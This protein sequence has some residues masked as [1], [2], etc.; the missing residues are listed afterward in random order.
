MASRNAI[1]YGLSSLILVFGVVAAA[2]SLWVGFGVAVGSAAGTPR[3]IARDTAHDDPWGAAARERMRARIAG[4]GASIPDQW[5]RA[6]TA[7]SWPPPWLDRQ[8]G[9][10]AASV[11][12]FVGSTFLRAPI[13][14]AA[15]PD[16][17][18]PAEKPYRQTAGAVRVHAGVEPATRAVR[19]VRWLPDRAA[20]Q[21]GAQRSDG[22]LVYFDSVRARFLG[23]GA[24][25]VQLSPADVAGYREIYRL[26]EKGDWAAA[27][28]A[29]ARLVD[30][31]LVGHLGL[32]RLLHPTA[33]VSRYDE[34]ARWL[35]DHGDHPGAGR[36]FRLAQIRRP[37]GVAAPAAPRLADAVYG[38]LEVEA[39]RAGERFEQVPASRRRASGPV[40]DRV[41][42]MLAQDRP[43]AAL[44]ALSGAKV[45]SGFSTRD[46]DVL[47]TR[48]AAVMFYGGNNRS[49]HA[50]AAASARRSGETVPQAPWIAGLAA[51]RAGDPAAAAPYFAMMAG[52]RSVS[53]WQ[54]AAAAFWAGRAYTAIG[55]AD[56]AERS[57]R[58]AARYG[59]TFYG[60]IARARLGLP[61]AFDWQLPRLT[62]GRLAALA[63]HPAGRRAIGLIQVGLTDLASDEL[64][65]INPGGDRFLREALLAL[66]DVTGLSDL[67]LRFGNAIT[68]PGGAPGRRTYDAL[69]YPVGRWQPQGGFQV[70][71][72][73]MLSLIRQESRFDRFARSRRG[74]AG[75]MQLMPA[76][77]RYVG[78][79][80]GDRLFDPEYNLT[81]GQRYVVR[82]LDLPEVAGNLFFL[83]A[84]YNGGPGNL[85]RWHRLLGKIDDPLLFVESIPFGQTR[86]F[87]EKLMANLWAYR[88]RLG[89]EPVTLHA[90]AN[91]RWPI[92]LPLEAQVTQVADN[93]A[94][95]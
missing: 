34:L 28:A 81:L 56:R 29:V 86:V 39:A 65:R 90:V 45:G 23:A 4:V 40:A 62:A 49:A 6:V 3:D 43:G 50:L 44:R 54:V 78:G 72:A 37:A 95:G 19:P 76:T 22:A 9:E 36:V 18:L 52:L 75:L 48:I 10:A 61:P 67:A 70:D 24:D 51:W 66:A 58:D 14:I 5:H 59:R 42:A 38:V 77:A 83:G 33:Y 32:Q 64:V 60:M 74:A 94:A 1:A 47:R 88:L 57:F 91:G 53:P 68:R 89:Q 35:R 27:D 82:L 12:R 73:L 15:E 46:Y 93:D 11:R 87:V 31:R 20:P 13:R 80:S 71:R 79:E 41:N 85:R 21:V 63:D 8:G 84:A 30:R 69:L 55:N 17:P 7:I 16:V 26:Q 25:E 2:P 92:Y